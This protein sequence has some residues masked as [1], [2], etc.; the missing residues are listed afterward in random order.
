MNKNTIAIAIAKPGDFFTPQLHANLEKTP[1]SKHYWSVLS[2]V[3][4][5]F[6]FMINAR[7]RFSSSRISISKKATL[8]PTFKILTVMDDY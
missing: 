7:F 6:H 2:T 5:L 4:H 3:L 8:E 1:G